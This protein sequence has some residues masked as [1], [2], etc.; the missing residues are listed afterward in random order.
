MK[1]S[2]CGLALLVSLVACDSSV[3]EDA[4][5]GQ[6][7]AVTDRGPTDSGPLDLGRPDAT[8]DDASGLDATAG[9]AAPLDAEP[10]DVGI[11]DAA[12]ADLGP[13]DA[14]ATDLGEADAGVVP[15]STVTWSAADGLPDQA[16]AG[17]TLVDTAEP[18]DPV[19]AGAVISLS[20]DTQTENLYYYQ[21]EAD[22]IVPVRLVMEATVRYV[23]G[24]SSTPSRSPGS[25]GFRLTPDRVKNGL[26]IEDGAIFLLES[27]NVRGPSVSLNTSDAQHSYR[28]EAEVALGGAIEVFQDDVLVLSG[29]TFQDPDVSAP[30]V[31]HF[32]EASLFA[33]G[34]TEWGAV[35]HNA[36]QPVICP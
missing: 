19:L 26:F 4:G 34:T 16:C 13:A 14:E 21:P 6:D 9:D 15:S 2:S 18:E 11:E 23:S 8:T 22:L 28:I 31:L 35:T 17:W 3:I 7:A 1:T 30:P 33:S 12:S 29:L 5:S 27:E 36:H 10:S 20:T 32:G 25:F 24:G